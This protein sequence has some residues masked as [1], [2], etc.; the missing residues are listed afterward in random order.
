MRREQ[1]VE[2]LRAAL[3]PLACVNVGWLG[4]SDELPGDTARLG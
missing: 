4:G 3:E 1:V 2:V